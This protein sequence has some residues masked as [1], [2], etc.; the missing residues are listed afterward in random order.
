MLDCFGLY[1][2]KKPHGEEEKE[3]DEEHR[4]WSQEGDERE[5]NLVS[6]EKNKKKKLETD[7]NLELKI[8]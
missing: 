4:E 2:V 7:N 5:I 3:E 1:S 6:F 8:L